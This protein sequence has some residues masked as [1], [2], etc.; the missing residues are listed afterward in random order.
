[1]RSKLETFTISHLA[2]HAG[3]NVETVRYY[4]RR[5]LMP[6]PDGGAGVRRYTE[7][8]AE[9]LRFIKRAQS[10]GFSLDEVKS[11]IQF[12]QKPSCQ[13]TR[14]LAITKIAAIDEQMSHLQQLRDD[15]ASIVDECASNTQEGD[16]PAIKRIEH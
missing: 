4:Q 5:G 6:L 7:N 1:M 15:L 11:L 13:A 9:K 10:F 16:C 14:A 8:D 2:R 12:R 3:V